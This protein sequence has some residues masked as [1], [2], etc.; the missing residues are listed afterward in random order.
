MEI[1]S[2]M[3]G[4][5]LRIVAKAGDQV[6]AGQDVIVLESMKME[7]PVSA[8]QPGTVAELNVAEGAFVQEGDLLMVL[9]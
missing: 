7:I 6:R 5:V 8:P 2:E 3:A 1:R 4:V 9:R